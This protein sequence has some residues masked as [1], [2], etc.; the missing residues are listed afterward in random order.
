L[1]AEPPCPSD[2]PPPSDSPAAPVMVVT[3]AVVERDGRFLMTRRFTGTHLAGYWEFPGGKCHV[4]EGLRECLRR[5]LREE[6]DVE[7]LVGEEILTT[8]HQYPDRKIRLHFY[9]CELAG[10]PKPALGQELRWVLRRDLND[11][12]LPPADEALVRL[13]KG[14]GAN[15][16]KSGQSDD[17]ST[18]GH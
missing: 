13:L 16:P 1:S 14:V 7:A 5:E 15:F 18:R 8:E 3:A 17:K 4:G 10:E 11:L 9:R 6:L 2:P 12:E